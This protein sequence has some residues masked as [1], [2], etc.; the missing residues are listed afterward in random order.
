M[1][2]FGKKKASKQAAGNSTGG[3][4]HW[5]LYLYFDVEKTNQKRKGFIV[6][7]CY[8]ELFRTVPAR[9]LIA[10]ML[11]AGDCL[12]DLRKFVIGISSQELSRLQKI[13][14]YIGK[15]VAF[16]EI[17][18]DPPMRLLSEYPTN[19][20]EPIIFD[21]LV[22][23]DMRKCVNDDNYDNIVYIETPS[24]GT[25]WAQKAWEKLKK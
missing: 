5:M 23:F 1:A 20:S 11:F 12:S 14:Q 25:G 13:Q 15:S 10:T 7:T 2:L 17:C 19:R 24:G 4:G 6:E 18:A 16:K 21:G 8:Q 22:R 9:E 3:L